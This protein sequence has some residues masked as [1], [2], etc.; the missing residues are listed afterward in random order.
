MACVKSRNIVYESTENQ[1]KAIAEDYLSVPLGNHNN[2]V[3]F[4][5]SEIS[6]RTMP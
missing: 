4:T 1:C 3:A 5:L 6:D 2:T